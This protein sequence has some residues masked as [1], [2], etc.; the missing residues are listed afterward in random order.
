MAYGNKPYGSAPL[1]GEVP[2]GE[3]P[4]TGGGS[5][6][7]RGRSAY[8]LLD[9]DDHFIFPVSAPAVTRVPRGPSL[10]EPFII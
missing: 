10:S 4:I 8:L 5:T 3:P 7:L 9:D 6:L 2:T 1:G